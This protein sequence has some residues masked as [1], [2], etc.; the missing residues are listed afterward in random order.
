MN[1]G[2]PSFF[3]DTI[4]ASLLLAFNLTTAA[5]ST[6]ESPKIVAGLSS[7]LP[8][9]L[10]NKKYSKGIPSWQCS[11]IIYSGSIFLNKHFIIFTIIHLLSAF[12]VN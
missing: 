2:T 9:R 6:A 3:S 7:E 4:L 1:I 8:Y 12:S 5:S 11:E 10:A